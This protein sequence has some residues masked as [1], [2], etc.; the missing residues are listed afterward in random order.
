MIYDYKSQKIEI[1]ENRNYRVE[2]AELPYL[3]MN[4]V[5]ALSDDQ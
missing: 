5:L 4:N 2:G 1:Y 3:Y